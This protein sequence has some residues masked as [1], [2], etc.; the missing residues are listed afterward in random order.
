MFLR[1]A[2][3]RLGC[4]AKNL[5]R[6]SFVVLPV[7]SFNAAFLISPAH[8]SCVTLRTRYNCTAVP[9]AQSV[10]DF[11]STSEVAPAGSHSGTSGSILAHLFAAA[12]NANDF[13]C[14]ATPS[15]SQ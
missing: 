1:P 6:I 4:P 3:L 13:S 15:A 2:L 5:H 7:S 10:A 9:P 11:A 14:D 8:Q 12:Q